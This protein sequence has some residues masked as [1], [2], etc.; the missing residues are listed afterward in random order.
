MVRFTGGHKRPLGTARRRW[1][2]RLALRAGAAGASLGIGLAFASLALADTALHYEL[3]FGT[4]GTGLGQFHSP[5]GIGI[6]PSGNVFVTQVDIPCRAQKFTRNGAVVM[7]IG[8]CGTGNAQ[9]DFSWDCEVDGQGNVYIVDTRNDRVQKFSNS[10]TWL[11]NI[12]GY[13]SADGKFNLPYGVAV[14]DGGAVYVTDRDNSRVQK[15]TSSGAF[16]VSKSS[17]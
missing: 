9:F 1:P 7:G 8:G 5:K 13:G 11:L 14:D 12:G 4:F 2:P 10:G 17:W 6:D 16:G 15:F 3:S